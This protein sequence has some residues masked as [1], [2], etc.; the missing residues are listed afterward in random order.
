MACSLCGIAALQVVQNDLGEIFCCPSCLEVARLLGEEAS[1]APEPPPLDGTS[2]LASLELSLSGLWCASCAWLIQERLNRTP[3]VRDAEVSFV[4][5]KARLHYDPRLTQAKRLKR[6]VKRLGYGAQLPEEPADDEE[7][8][9]FTRMLIGGV[10]AMH[11]MVVSIMLYGR[12]WL[13]LASPDTQWLAD[14]FQLMLFVASIPILLL[15]GVPILRAGIAS[16]LRGRPNTHTLI[17]LGAFSAFG[18]SVRNLFFGAEHVYFDTASML[19]FLVTIGRW[20]EIQAHKSNNEAVEKL[21]DQLPAEATWIT[22]DGLKSVPATSLPL[23]ARVRVRPGER[24]PVDGLV[25][26]GAGDVDESLLTGEPTPQCRHEGEMVLAGTINLDGAFEVITSAIGEQTKA[27]KIGSL[28]HQALWQR[29]P[30]E[31]LADR[32]AAWMIPTAI[33]IAG[34]TFIFW[35]QRANPEI[36]LL[37]GLS[38]LLIACPCALGLATPL[39]L[40]QALNRAAQHGVIFRSTAALERLSKIERIFFDKTGTLT[41]L[42]LRLQNIAVRTDLMEESQAGAMQNGLNQATAALLRRAAAVEELSEHPLADAVVA[43]ARQANLELPIATEFRSWPG[44]GVRARVAGTAISIG[45]ERFMTASEL[46]LA[47]DLARQ[48]ES[49][50][51]SGQSVVYVGWGGEVQGLLGF[52]EAARPGAVAVV[53]ELK[54]RADEVIILTGDDPAAGKRW[55]RLLNVPVYAGLLPQNKLDFLRSA[56]GPSVMVG[57]GINDGPALAAASVGIAMSRGTDV[58]RTAAEIVL[59]RDDLAA[60]PWL[61]DLSAE[62]MRRIRQNLVWAFSYNLIGIALAVSGH[63]QPVLAAAAMVLSSLIVTANAVKLKRFPGLRE[64]DEALQ[65]LGIA[66][67]VTGFAEDPG[68]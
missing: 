67:Y 31:R 18:L 68:A 30:V 29:S 19:I 53:D 62:T 39:T 49:W 47:E 33:G 63:L 52:G 44:Q 23:G 13:G 5:K 20:L 6:Q 1:E 2:E 50:R 55:E 25:V 7:D 17:A 41:Q 22:D 12:E 59:V 9:F 40:W 60:I 36:G 35:A 48:A 27:G 10:F 64:V 26:K 43:K 3:G 14:F 65:P 61:M 58:A 28:L 11:V 15:L 38:V 66:A 42:P 45:N 51:A 37:N 21:M 4:H 8:S 56:A 34:V 32:L 24:F 57:D 46:A 54:K 16:L